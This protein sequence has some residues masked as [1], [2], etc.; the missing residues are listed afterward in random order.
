MRTV[1][2][3]IRDL[4]WG[5]LHEQHGRAPTILKE[6]NYVL[7][8]P[9]VSVGEG[10]EEVDPDGRRYSVSAREAYVLNGGIKVLPENFFLQRWGGA[11]VHSSDDARVASDIRGLLHDV[12]RHQH[13]RDRAIS[14]R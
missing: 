10:Y 11:R 1:R 4:E 2:G 7:L 3:A 12:L 13:R 6:G 8:H 5:R 9:V 14:R